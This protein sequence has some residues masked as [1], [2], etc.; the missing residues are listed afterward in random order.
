MNNEVSLEET[1]KLRLKA[2]L[3]PI[4]L[5]NA[6]VHAEPLP[7]KRSNIVNV[8]PQINLNKD[9]KGAD[10]DNGEIM[11]LKDSDILDEDQNELIT[12][13]EVLDM[14]LNRQYRTLE[15][16]PDGTSNEDDVFKIGEAKI[17][18]KLSE[19]A[20]EEKSQKNML[21]RAAFTN[22]NLVKL[23]VPIVEEEDDFLSA[24]TNQDYAKP[25]KAKLKKLKKKKQRSKDFTSN[26]FPEELFDS[27]VSLKKEDQIFNPDSEL[28]EMLDIR[29]NKVAKKR[30]AS[31]K[32]KLEES[33]EENEEATGLQVDETSDFLANLKRRLRTTKQIN[34][35]GEEQGEP[36]ESIGPAEIVTEQVDKTAGEAVFEEPDFNSGLASTLAFLKQSS[37][38]K[39]EPESNTAREKPDKDR[40]SGPMAA[41]NPVV[42]IKYTD[43]DNN[44]LTRKEAYKHLSHKFHGKGPSKKKQA[45]QL[46][47]RLKT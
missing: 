34:V 31:K 9:L 25:K 2:G 4:I 44:E 8:R 32:H 41:Y 19:E 24:I 29:R 3:K 36:K 10:L 20:R 30:E 17:R 22:R 45:K 43:D 33:E 40:G 13:K 42:K 47:K 21:E 1:N 27:Y 38:I 11:T 18:L 14:Q 26:L 35:S 37:I 15:T 6:V 39:D 46:A 23:S 12:E 7:A 16:K 28:Q 5:T